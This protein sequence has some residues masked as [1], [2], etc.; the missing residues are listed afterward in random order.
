[1]VGVVLRHQVSADQ[2][3]SCRFAVSGVVAP[4]LSESLVRQRST[5]MNHTLLVAL[6]GFGSWSSCI[7]Q[8]SPP[9]EIA[10]YF[11]PPA[12]LS[13]E[14]GAYKSPLV[15]KDGTK[16]QSAAD[17]PKRR[18]EILGLPHFGERLHVGLVARETDTLCDVTRHL[19]GI[20]VDAAVYDKELHL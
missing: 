14:V 10:P 18:A 7:A 16:V 12:A 9:A 6:I 11:K 13:A 19:L 5:G 3:P 2:P 4:G 1:M 15:F 17:W 20:A 8:S